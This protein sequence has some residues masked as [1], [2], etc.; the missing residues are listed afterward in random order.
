MVDSLEMPSKQLVSNPM[1]EQALAITEAAVLVYDVCDAASFRLAQNLAE[2]MRE[3]F[4]A[5][6]SSPPGATPAVKGT[7][8]YALIL[9]GNKADSD[10][11]ADGDDDQTQQQPRQV[12][13]AEGSKAAARMAMPGCSSALGV[14]FLEVSAKTG[15][16]V[17]QIFP[18]VGRE[19]LRMRRLVAQQ[20]E[21]QAE[22]A[23]KM[24]QEAR[25]SPVGRD[26]K[27]EVGHG[28]RSTCASWKALFA[29][30]RQAVVGGERRY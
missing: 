12:T 14:A 25:Q 3:H 17:D 20:R 7:R 19:I 1:I 16:N 22:R 26:E 6:S 27:R 9:V 2:F 29:G 5:S 24:L 28:G 21:Q 18:A 13:W 8:P 23:M 10:T 4:T 15:E 30:R 11:S